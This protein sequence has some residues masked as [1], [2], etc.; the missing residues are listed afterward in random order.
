MNPKNPKKLI[1][2]KLLDVSTSSM[3]IVWF[4][5]LWAYCPTTL[6]LFTLWRSFSQGLT[7]CF[8]EHAFFQTCH[9]RFL[10]VLHSEGFI[11][12]IKTDYFSKLNVFTPFIVNH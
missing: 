8:E 6:H 2:H 9:P 3:A 11:L 7:V 5:N 1:P 4:L 12:T 10:F